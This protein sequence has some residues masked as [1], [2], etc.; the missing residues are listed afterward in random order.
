MKINSE[1]QEWMS[2]AK[3][4]TDQITALKQQHTELKSSFKKE[5]AMPEKS[6]LI[7]DLKR[8]SLVECLD[9]IP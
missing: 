9:R 1:Q 7:Q 8:M 6:A 3:N 5:V 4:L 2:F